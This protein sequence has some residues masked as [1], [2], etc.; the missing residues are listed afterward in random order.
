MYLLDT[1]VL[2][3][4]RKAKTNKINKAVRVWAEN[5]PAST[6]YLSVI[7]VLEIELGVLLKERKD[8][9]QGN[10]LRVWLNDHV[11]PTFRSRILDVDTSIA[12]KCASLHVPDP[13]SY[14]DSLIAATAIVHQ[15]TIVTRNVSDFFQPGVNVINPWDG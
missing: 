4:L 6:L 8:P 9:W 5:V 3:E 11:M 15:L 1:N 12:V 13:K 2:S 7:T 14:R 10:I